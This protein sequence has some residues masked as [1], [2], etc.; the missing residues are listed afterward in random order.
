MSTLTERINWL[1]QRQSMQLLDNAEVAN[2]KDYGAVK[3]IPLSRVTVN[4]HILG[5]DEPLLT[6]DGA[7]VSSTG[8]GQWGQLYAAGRY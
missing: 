8:N 5:Y 4:G 7:V 2:Y 6:A 1:N 3:E